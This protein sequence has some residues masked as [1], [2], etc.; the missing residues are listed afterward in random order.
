MPASTC[1]IS[2][3]P[4]HTRPFPSAPKSSLVQAWLPAVPSSIISRLCEV[5]KVEEDAFTLMDV[6][7]SNE[8]YGRF[9]DVMRMLLK[10]LQTLPEYEQL[11]LLADLKE[12]KAARTAAQ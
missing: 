12:N 5:L 4:D 11:R 9:S 3:P 1:F 7:E 8:G 2:S 6:G 10:E